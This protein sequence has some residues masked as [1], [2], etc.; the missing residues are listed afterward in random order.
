M[1]YSAQEDRKIFELFA[2]SVVPRIYIV[3]EDG[4]IR[5]I[6]TDNPLATFDDLVEAIKT[7]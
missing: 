7:I 1:P 3:D 5:Y 4:I 6:F 2:K